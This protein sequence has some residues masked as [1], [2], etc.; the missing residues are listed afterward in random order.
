VA[1]LFA[2]PEQAAF[3]RVVPKSKIYAYGK[4]G[5]RVRELIVSQVDQIV[6]R[7]KL[8]PE[9]VKLSERP[10]VP[11]IQ[12]FA[13]ALKGSALDE[14][15]LR[16][17]DKAIP[18]PIF[19]ELGH[20]SRIKGVAAYKR[21]NEADPGKWI[22]GDYFET[23]WLPAESPREGMPVA[24]DLAG[25][26]EQ[27]L[28]ALIPEPARRSE[29]LKAHME[30]IARI[31]GMQAEQ[32]KLELRLQREKQFNRKVELNAQIRSIKREIEVLTG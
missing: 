31:R 21:R 28:R 4:P 13:I 27:M 12:V 5:T 1:A 11:E 18:F 3:D 25:L 8:S 17:I 20:K 15:V 10:G 26:Y 23:A 2:Y 16:C 7:Y 32:K 9:T 29:S 30:R 19:Y 14:E 6:W 24:L 22:V